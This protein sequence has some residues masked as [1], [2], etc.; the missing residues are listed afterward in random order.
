MF[1]DESGRDGLEKPMKTIRS[2][3]DLKRFREEIIEEKQRQASLGKVQ[4][5]VS[6]GSCGIAAGALETLKALQQQVEADG[7][8]NVSIS[9]S[10]CIGLC[11]HEPILEVVAGDS[12]KVTYG[13]VTPQIV[14][15]IIREHILGGRIV[16][17]FVIESTPFPKI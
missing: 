10:G 1:V 7:L 3:E 17:D 6:L 12:P 11:K 15:R 13:S 8:K 5:I 14:Q 16:E 2:L 9:Q 4:V